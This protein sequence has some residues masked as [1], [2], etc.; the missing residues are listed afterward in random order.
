MTL[1]VPRL[2]K[3]IAGSRARVDKANGGTQLNNGTIDEK[4]QKISMEMMLNPNEAVISVTAQLLRAIE[5]A[6]RA[7]YQH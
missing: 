2:N 3:K 5:K 4:S 7:R 6:V 1:A